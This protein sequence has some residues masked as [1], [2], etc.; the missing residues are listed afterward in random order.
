VDDC[1]T[2][3]NYP[4]IFE[5][6]RRSVLRHVNTYADSHGG[7]FEHL[8]MSSFSYNS[9][10]KCFQTHVHMDTLFQNVSTFQLHLVYS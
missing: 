2:I 9:Q 6:M 3:P 8:E 7:H 1:Q 5:R 4:G 10:I